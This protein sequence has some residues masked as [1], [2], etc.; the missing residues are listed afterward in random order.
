VIPKLAKTHLTAQI[1][2]GEELGDW[3]KF[4]KLWV[5]SVHAWN[6]HEYRKTKILRYLVLWSGYHSLLRSYAHASLGQIY[7]EQ[8]S[9]VNRGVR[10]FL[11]ALQYKRILRDTA[12]IVAA[13]MA[14]IYEGAGLYEE[15]EKLNRFIPNRPYGLDVGVSNQIRQ[16]VSEKMD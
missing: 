7:L 9:N 3:Q 12:L 10:H 4:G 15:A 1:V 14:A 13:Y 11:K 8:E 2:S 5:M 16:L 6:N